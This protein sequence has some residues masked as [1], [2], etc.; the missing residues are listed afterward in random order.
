MTKSGILLSVLALLSLGACSGMRNNQSERQESM[1]HERSPERQESS[2][3][4]SSRAD[5]Y[6]TPEAGSDHPAAGPDMR[7]EEEAESFSESDSANPSGSD[8]PAIG[9]DMKQKEE[10]ESFSEGDTSNP[11]GSD[12]PAIGD[13]MKEEQEARE[14]RKADHMPGYETHDDHEMEAE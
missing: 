10:A 1:A 9:D 13:D 2:F 6:G 3:E 8:H 7:Q 11:S 12:H 5:N 14:E 4:D